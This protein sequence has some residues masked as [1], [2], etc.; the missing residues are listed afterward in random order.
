MRHYEHLKTTRVQ[1]SVYEQSSNAAV[2]KASIREVIATLD[3]RSRRL[4]A[5]SAS[6]SAAILISGESDLLLSIPGIG[7]TTAACH[8]CSECSSLFGR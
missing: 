1:Q 7:E 2:V 3:A 6:T 5:K 4:S 8:F